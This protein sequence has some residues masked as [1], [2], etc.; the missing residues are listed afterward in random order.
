[1]TD[2]GTVRAV[3]VTGAGGLVGSH[4]CEAF[5]EDGWEVRA[6]DRPGSDCTAARAAGATVSDVELAQPE[7]ALAAARLAKGNKVVAHAAFPGANDRE[8]ALAAVRGAMA[9]AL[10]A[11]G[12]ALRLFA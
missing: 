8:E 4:L 6:L 3:L 12:A 2:R 11:G 7:G 9:A 5:A 1:M 10:P